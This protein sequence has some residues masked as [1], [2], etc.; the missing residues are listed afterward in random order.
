MNVE[1]TV[2]VSSTADRLW[3]IIADVKA[4]PEWQ[5]TSFVRSPTGRLQKGT[6]FAAELGGLKWA[7][8]VTEAHRPNT[9]TWVGRRPG[10][11][12]VHEWEFEEEAGGTKA[13]T[14]EAMSGWMLPLLYPIVKR[15]LPAT[16]ERW[17][18]DLKTRAEN[19]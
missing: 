15:K 13:T 1:Y 8:T 10:L 14:R 9:L 2:H 18:T 7:V 11:R 3:D 19:T 4:W 17:L 16:D 5:G 12:G 6:T